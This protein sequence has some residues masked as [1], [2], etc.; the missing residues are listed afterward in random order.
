M[1]SKI[2]L[3]LLVSIL[4]FISC[5]KE[6]KEVA[7]PANDEAVYMDLSALIKSSQLKSAAVG[8]VA[9]KNIAV[10]KAEYIT[11]GESGKIGRT[12]Y[13]KDYGNKRLQAD[14]VPQ[15][16]LCLD[17]TTDVSYYIDEN[18]PCAYL[19]V[20][21]ASGAIQ[22]AMGTWGSVSCSQLGMFQ[23]PSSDAIKTGF[24][25]EYLGYDGSYDYVA[26]VTH[27]GWLPADFFDLLD[28]GGGSFILAVTFTIIFITDEGV[29]TDVDNNKMS[30]VA[31]REIY[32]N[33]Y[34][35]WNIG[36]HYDVETIALHE[37]GHGLSQAHFGTAFLDA[38]GGKLHFSPRAVMNAAYSGIQTTIAQTDKAGHCSIWANWPLK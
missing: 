33:D 1:K 31:W 10:L 29:P 14:F 3:L 27:C 5:E 18:R 15:L 30:D 34:F 19:S 21:A 22:K 12:I 38:G 36:A 26:D 32:Y 13:F 20:S 17:G 7:I 9:P 11:T 23:K 8:V 35:T 28:Y 6:T 24:I 25:Y 4:T 2:A 16:P 37:A